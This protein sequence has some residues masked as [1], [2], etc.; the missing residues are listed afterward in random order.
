MKRKIKERS[1]K[2]E[3]P[4]EKPDERKTKKKI[5]TRVVKGNKKRAIYLVSNKT[6]SFPAA[7]SKR[8]ARNE[9]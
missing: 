7:P 9:T 1:K 4:D 2:N 3:K 8:R 5:K 6:K